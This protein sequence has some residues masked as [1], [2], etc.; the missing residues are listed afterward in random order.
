MI[1]FTLAA[2]SSSAACRQKPA[3]APPRPLK[4]RNWITSCSKPFSLAGAFEHAAAATAQFCTVLLQASQERKGTGILRD[5][6]AKLANVGAACG[7]LL[8][9]A[10]LI[11]RFLSESRRASDN[12]HGCCQKGFSHRF[13]MHW[14]LSYFVFS[15]QT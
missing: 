14:S 3:A 4:K 7:P 11:G 13:S 8:G 2:W 6:T 15:G 10:H 12:H 9:R 1:R 5:R